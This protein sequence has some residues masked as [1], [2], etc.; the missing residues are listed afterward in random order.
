MRRTW[1]FVVHRSHPVRA[2]S[3]A[4]TP[5]LI[6]LQRGGGWGQGGGGGGARYGIGGPPPRQ[7]YPPQRGGGGRGNGDGGRS[8]GYGSRSQ[9][10]YDNRQDDY[11]QRQ[12][13]GY[14]DSRGRGGYSDNRRHGFD[15]RPPRRS[16]ADFLQQ[17][18]ETLLQ[19]KQ[20]FK[21]SKT[22]LERIQIL[23]EGRR[24]VRR[25]HVDASTQDERSVIVFLNC[26]ATFKSG[27]TE[28]VEEASQ[29]VQ[30][31]IRGL[32]PHNVALY[33]NALG[34]L[35]LTDGVKVVR[36]VVVP[37]LPSLIRDMTPVEV[38]MVLQAFQR[39]R[40]EG[41]DELKDSML[42]QLE[43]CVSTMPVPQLST[44]AEVLVKHR[45]RESNPEN[46]GRIV[47]EV[48]RKALSSV[49]TMHSKEVITFLTAVPRLDLPAEQVSDLLKRA[50]ATAGFHDDVQVATLF[51][52]IYAVKKVFPEATPELTAAV[53]ALQQALV[54]RLERVA[55]FVNAE[56]AGTI[57]VNTARSHI[58]LPTAITQT[59]YK[60]VQKHL[61]YK[62][63]RVAQL[64]RLA[65]GLAMGPP[66]SAELLDMVAKYAVGERP[67]RPPK[68]TAEGE[69][70]GD[71]QDEE[72]IANLRA[73]KQE[74]LYARNFNRY[75][76]LR[77]ELEGAYAKA[78]AKPPEALT[79]TLPEHLVQHIGETYASTLLSGIWALLST[80]TECS[81]RNVANDEA[82]YR[83]VLDD[84]TA[85]PEKYKNTVSPQFMA[86]LET[87]MFGNAKGEELVK[88]VRRVRGE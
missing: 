82:L 67:P 55:S 2:Y 83:G 39:L 68:G 88:A 69:H 86:K 87:A 45:L 36:E 24:L 72:E 18:A 3:T 35:D 19:M 33:C 38:V 49:E 47:Q 31:N 62:T 85:N 1:T 42:L 44:L 43:P 60:A 70:D 11:D 76:S 79:T 22:R 10:D 77:L 32:S 23:R 78:G 14:S 30:L 8:Q 37:L 61:T 29:W 40:I 5:S 64:E 48:M 26:A 51:H 6:A 81:C 16:A 41:F 56:T 65:K 74:S 17:N 75:V 7:H 80:P 4:L 63:V 25:T 12:R 58:E 71:A 50:T 57:L 27:A 28:G 54:L 59:I 84:I 53:D 46:W 66:P 20:A 15:D 9:R 21:Q 13:G 52:S 73:A 34:V